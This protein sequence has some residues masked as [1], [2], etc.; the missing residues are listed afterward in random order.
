MLKIIAD[1]AKERRANMVLQR[2]ELVLF[3]RG[4]DVT[5]EVM[6]KLDEQMPVLTVNFVN[7]QPPPAAIAAPPPVAPPAR[8]RRR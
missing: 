4:F 3:D 2:T 5:D 6:Q 7:P 1:I 8:T